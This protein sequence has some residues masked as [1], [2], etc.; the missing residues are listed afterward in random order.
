MK[1]I[2]DVYEQASEQLVNYGKSGIMFSLNV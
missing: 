2:L 1:S